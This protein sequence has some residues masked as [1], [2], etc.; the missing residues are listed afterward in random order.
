MIVAKARPEDMELGNPK[1]KNCYTEMHARS[2]CEEL[3]LG[4]LTE[5]DIGAYL[6]AHFSPNEFPPELAAMIHGRT[7]GHP[8]FATGAIELLAERGDIVRANGAWRLKQPLAQIE[9]DAPVSVRSMIEKKVSLLDADGRQTLIYASVEGEEFTSTVLAALLEADDLELEERLHTIEKVHRLIRVEREQDL[10]DGS[11]ATVYRFTH[12]LYRDFLYDHLLSKRRVLLH[13]RAGETL[14]RVYG[15][16]RARIAGSLA[17]HFER[18]RDFSRAVT[19]FIGAGETALSRFAYAEAAGHYSHGLGLVDRLTEQEQGQC[20]AVLLNKRG[21]AYLSLGCL[22]EAAADYAAMREACRAA[23]NLEGESRAAIGQTTVAF[24]L[25]EVDDCARYARVAIALAERTGNDALI[26]HAGVQWGVHVGVTGRL[27]EAQSQYDRCIP[28][29]RS[30]GHRAALPVGLMYQGLLHFWKSEYEAAERTQV[31][32]PMWLPKFG[33]VSTWRWHCSTSDWPAPTAAT[34]RKPWPLLR[35]PWIP[36]SV[37]TTPWPSRAFPTGWA[38]CGARSAIWA[39]PSSSTR[40][41][42][43]SPA[44]AGSPK[45]RRTAGLT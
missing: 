5:P 22:P 6:D 14:E 34:S 15:N 30:A 43:S 35:R 38:G 12:A 13:R 45:P 25:R 36:L 18:G 1:L 8:L 10:P 40:P 26:A 7:E 16:Q 41:A 27:A 21:S 44:A 33:T 20:R 3:A 19:Y 9:L 32:A 11:V 42:L 24:H 4:A 2:I 17:S 23:G 28:L 31:E 39:R 29:A 37:T